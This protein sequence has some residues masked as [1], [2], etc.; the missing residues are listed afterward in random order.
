MNGLLGGVRLARWMGW[1]YLMTGI[2]PLLHIRSFVWMT[3]PKTDRWLVKA[4]GG[5]VTAT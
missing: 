2:W 5:L 4:V 1:Y 3:G